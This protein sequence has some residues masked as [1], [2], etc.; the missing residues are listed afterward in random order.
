MRD[1]ENPHLKILVLCYEYPPLGGGGGRVAAQVAH[2]LARRGHSVRVQTAGMRHLP[3][4]EDQDG[5]EILRSHS[6][7]KR[8]DTCSVPEMALYLLTSFLPALRLARSWRPDVI[9]AH[10]AVPTGVLAF[11]I[12]RLTGIPYVLTA[13]LGDV[14]GG[15]PEQTAGLFRFVN[16]FARILWKGA[17]HT[18]A[19]SSFVAGLA[20]Q[21]YAIDPTIIRNGVEA[22]KNR[23]S[24]TP[25]ANINT[26][27]R[28]VFAGRLSVQKN[29]LLA[30]QALAKIP[31]LPW[32]FDIIGE[33]PL[34]EALRAE[35]ARLG[36]EDRVTFHGWMAGEQV[37]EI[38]TQADILLMTSLHE[39]LPMVGV[40]ALQHGL[41]I[42]GS[43]IGGMQD[44]VAGNED[45]Q[46]NGFLCALDADAFADRLRTVL[47]DPALL[48]AMQ[49]ASLC[50]AKNFELSASVAAY[51]QVLKEAAGVA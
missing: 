41:A 40:E 13:H 48:A 8:E 4:R 50:R 42:I 39:G 6:F 11:A 15:V 46:S 10:F 31:D 24:R 35:T 3:A 18:T 29:P 21:A 23:I 20:R 45:K 16:P 47:S 51:E 7:R 27:P 28:L 19:V 49:N 17:T 5:V 1:K 30:V 44:L 38:M 34:G 33:G 26:P 14:P 43:A 9:H 12:S 2:G 22:P 36:L 25:K 37:A 32:T